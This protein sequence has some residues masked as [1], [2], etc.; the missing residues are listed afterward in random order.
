LL[1][2]TMRALEVT[3]LEGP[4]AVRLRDDVPVPQPRAGEVLV[5]VSAAGL[6]F[7]DVMQTRGT[8]VGG[9]QPPFCPGSEFAGEVLAL[10]EGTVGP[11]VGTRVMG[12]GAGACAEYVAAPARMVGPV[13][14]GWSDAQAAAFRV[15]WL[16]A[17]GCLRTVGRLAASE[18]VLIHAVAGGVGLAALHLARHFG[19]TVIGTASTAEKLALA[20]QR[21]LE[22]GINVRE[23]DFVAEVK[24]LT[25][26][27]GADLVLEMVGGETFARNFEAVR[28]FGRIVVFGAASA[29]QAT[30]SNVQMIFQPVE[31]I[32][33]HL[34]VLGRR[35]PDLLAQEMVEVQQ[36]IQ[37]GVIVPESAR[38]WPLAE[39]ARALA[40]L[41]A[42]ETVGKQVLVP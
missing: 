3:A 7:A 41:E 30:V 15:Q 6:N 9:P 29:E 17:H 4:Q 32:G 40:A 37:D 26:G 2:R 33:Y 34:L 24:R 16:T 23:Q 13:P 22:H 5:R 12:V 35:R 21:G 28:P 18:T 38:E 27:R 42:R 20:E 11:L 36:L 10:G 14:D 25:G 19:A 1:P 31:L 8:Y 39:G